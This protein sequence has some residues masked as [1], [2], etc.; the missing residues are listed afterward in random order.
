VKIFLDY[1]GNRSDHRPDVVDAYQWNPLPKSNYVHVQYISRTDSVYLSNF[2]TVGSVTGRVYGVK[3]CCTIIHR[4]SLPEVRTSSLVTL[5]KAGYRKK[6][7]VFV[8]LC[9][10]L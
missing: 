2:N 10:V 6:D 4:G 7:S 9:V 3:I 5:G 1:V 8:C